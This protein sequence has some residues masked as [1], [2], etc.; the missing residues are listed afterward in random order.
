MVRKWSIYGRYAGPYAVCA[1]AEQLLPSLLKTA[2]SY[3]SPSIH[4]HGRPSHQVPLLLRP[5][6]T[7]LPLCN[8]LQRPL[9]Y[10]LFLFN[11]QHH[12]LS[13]TSPGFP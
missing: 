3:I 7:W 12:S 1:V 13:T 8:K 6:P 4:P 2:G 9:Q 11:S 10:P 5:Y